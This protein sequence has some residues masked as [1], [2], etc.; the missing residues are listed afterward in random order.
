MEVVC[1]CV[2]VC[3]VGEWVLFGNVTVGSRKCLVL[4][5]CSFTDSPQ[6]LGQRQASVRAGYCPGEVSGALSHTAHLY[7]HTEMLSCVRS[8]NC[9][10][11]I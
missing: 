3:C 8:C 6:G 4:Y 7:G 2:C 11:G 1:V 9:E 10:I 5:S